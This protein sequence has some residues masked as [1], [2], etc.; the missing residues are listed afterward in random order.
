MKVGGFSEQVTV[1]GET[2]SVSLG[3]TTA[4]GVVTTQQIAEL[5]LNGRSFMQLATLQPGVIVSR[6][7]GA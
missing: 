7:H 1:A 6:A 2:S 3:A 5:P 4:G